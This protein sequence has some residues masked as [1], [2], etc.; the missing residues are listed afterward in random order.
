MNMKNKILHRAARFCALKSDWCHRNTSLELPDEPDRQSIILAILAFDI[1][2]AK[3][4]SPNEV[5]AEAEAFIRSGDLN[6][7][8]IRFSLNANSYFLYEVVKMTIK[9]RSNH[10][11]L[12]FS[13]IDASAMYK[14]LKK[15]DI[16]F[17][18]K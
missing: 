4:Q 6:T 12:H 5:W 11:V 3:H 18:H 16:K 10:R 9:V 1:V 7:M 15:L 17:S 13:P 8:N 2:R 14:L